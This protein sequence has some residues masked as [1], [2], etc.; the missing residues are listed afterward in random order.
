MTLDE[1]KDK[2]MVILINFYNTHIIMI[3]HVVSNFMMMNSHENK[4][5]KVL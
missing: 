4:K 5:Y 2:T 1:C 3:L